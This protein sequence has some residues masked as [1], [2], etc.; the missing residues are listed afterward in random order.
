MLTQVLTASE[1]QKLLS[2]PGY[3]P[4]Q[5]NGAQAQVLFRKLDESTLYDTAFLDQ[6]LVPAQDEMLYSIPIAGMLNNQ[7]N[8]APPK[9]WIFHTSFCCSTLLARLLQVEGKVLSMKEPVIL[10]QLADAFRHNPN[11]APQYTGLFKRVA[12]Q[13]SKPFNGEQRVV[14]K[15]SNYMNALL[16]QV[17]HVNSDSRVLLV[18]GD[19]RAFTRS[20][21]K[22]RAE[23]TKTMPIFLRA[24]QRDV[25]DQSGYAP[26]TD[27]MHDI[28]HMWAVQI[29]LFCEFIQSTQLQVATI[30]KQAILNNTQSTVTACDRFFSLDLQ[31]NNSAIT[32]IMNRDSKRQSNQPSVSSDINKSDEHER[33]LVAVEAIA[34]KLIA[35]DALDVLEQQAL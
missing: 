17:H 11:N 18:W 21:L 29:R 7:D 28:A 9:N 13:L 30:K 25:D 15:T 14:L 27:F 12:D 3:V 20:M 31:R 10:N 6:R 32:D 24:L 34:N 22:N 8:I 4:W 5:I 26:G 1:T 16:N 23:S 35:S 19:I 33:T 2:T